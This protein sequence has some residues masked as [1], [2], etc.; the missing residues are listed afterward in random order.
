MADPEQDIQISVIE[1]KISFHSI[2]TFTSDSSILNYVH[3]LPVIAS[4]NKE[5]DPSLS[6]V[7]DGCFGRNIRY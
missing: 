6:N 1:E 5:F 2:Q 3:S 7:F 4:K